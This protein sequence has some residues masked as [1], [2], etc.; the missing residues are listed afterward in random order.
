MASHFSTML[1]SITSA[2]FLSSLSI[3]HKFIDEAG[4]IF[5]VY[6]YMYKLSLALLYSFLFS[7]FVHTN[8]LKNKLNRQRSV[9]NVGN[10]LCATPAFLA[11]YVY[12]ISARHGPH[13]PDRKRG[14]TPSTL[15]RQSN[16]RGSPVSCWPSLHVHPGETTP[17]AL[18]RPR[19]S[20]GRRPHPKRHTLW[21][22]C[23]GRDK[24]A[25]A[26][27]TWDSRMSVRETWGPSISTLSPGK[28]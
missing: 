12:Y 21:R 25:S 27:R 13:M 20:H 23:Y 9:R 22:A 5:F 6:K 3:I 2:S 26:A 19:S 7:W 8:K 10:K 14:S 17:D 28:T 16:Q 11:P 24:E 4:K 15:A 18:V 1:E